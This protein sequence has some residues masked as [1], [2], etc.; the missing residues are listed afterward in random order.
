MRIS[1]N[2]WCD[3]Q[4]AK[5]VSM[6]G[7]QY[8]NRANDFSVAVE[9]QTNPSNESP[10]NEISNESSGDPKPYIHLLVCG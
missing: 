5:F 1:F 7:G 9:G 8:H 2:F 4:I 6:E 10:S 3:T